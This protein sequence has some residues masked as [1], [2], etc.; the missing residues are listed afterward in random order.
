MPS[1]LIKRNFSRDTNIFAE[2]IEEGT[3][4]II[5]NEK[6]ETGTDNGADGIRERNPGDNLPQNI[7]KITL[8]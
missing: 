7:K 1:M 3:A 5:S 6:K 8:F 2:F 4:T